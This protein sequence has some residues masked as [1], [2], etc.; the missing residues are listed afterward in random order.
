MSNYE[1]N[2]QNVKTIFSLVKV[3]ENDIRTDEEKQVIDWIKEDI[4]EIYE[5]QYSLKKSSML[6]YAYKTKKT[7]QIKQLQNYIKEKKIFKIY[8]IVNEELSNWRDINLCIK[9]CFCKL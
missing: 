1:I 9:T 8:N 5:I 4:S 6:V 3:F 7:V 2:I